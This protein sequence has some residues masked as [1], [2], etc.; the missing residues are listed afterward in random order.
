MLISIEFTIAVGDFFFFDALAGNFERVVTGP[1]GME[2]TQ[3]GLNVARHGNLLLT[4]SRYRDHRRKPDE[5]PTEIK[6]RV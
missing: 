3:F 6:L 5:S 1:S 4:G 2:N